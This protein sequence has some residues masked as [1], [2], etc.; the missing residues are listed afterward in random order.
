VLLASWALAAL[1]SLIPPEIRA[2]GEIALTGRVLAF[3]AGLAA[4]TA[5]VFGVVPAW[6]SASADPAEVLKQAG[7]PTAHGGGRRLRSLLVAGEIAV[8]TVLLVG[9]ALLGASFAHVVDED[10]GFDPAGLWVA[11]VPLTG[12]AYADEEKVR[13]AYQRLGDAVQ[14]IPGIESAAV[15]T[16]MPFLPID[17]WAPLWRADRPRPPMTELDNARFHGVSPGYFATLRARLVAGR[18]F[19]AT[20]D[21]A[22]AAAVMI[23]SRAAASKLFGDEPPLGKRLFA[24]LGDQGAWE[25]IGVAGDIKGGTLEEPDAVEIYVPFRRLNYPP[26]LAAV[27]RVAP[28]VDVRGALRAAAGTADPTL[29]PPEVKPLADAMR[30]TLARRKLNTLLLGSFAAGA[31]LLALIGIYGVMSYTVSQERQ[32]IAI[33]MAM[34]ATSAAITRRVVARALVLAVAGVAAGAAGAFALTQLL[35]SLLYGVSAADPR[36]FAAAAAL[37]VVVA[38][39]A[40]WLPARRAARVPPMEALRV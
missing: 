37:Q 6:Q 33:R 36:A 12:A 26:N 3:S 15:G 14:A 7:G 8:A 20:D 9:A 21:R 16:A 38:V 34:G 23:I 24:G 4:L 22:D 11:H 19:A 29:P 2:L 13:A 28:G 35:A 39:A 5:V 30:G 25:I 31:L 32:E 18:D 40:A 1:S 10:P 17:G 27:V